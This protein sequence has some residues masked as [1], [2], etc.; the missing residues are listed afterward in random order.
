MVRQRVCACVLRG[1]TIVRRKNIRR[2]GQTSMP[3]RCGHYMRPGRAQPANG[4]GTG[5]SAASNMKLYEP[6][7][8]RDSVVE[9]VIIEEARNEEE[10]NVEMPRLPQS[11]RVNAKRACC[12]NMNRI[13][14]EQRHAAR[15][16]ASGSVRLGPERQVVGKN[17]ATH[18]Q[19]HWH[20]AK[21]GVVAL[22]GAAAEKR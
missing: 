3:R 19:W 7:P 20:A 22:G 15:E 11:A 5:I 18:R 6:P 14:L 13:M 4:V 21:Q 8:D 9:A 10:Q 2:I 1:R 16:P 12:V 17:N